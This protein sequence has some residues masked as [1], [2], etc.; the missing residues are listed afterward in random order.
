MKRAE[1]YKLIVARDCM[2][3]VAEA[4]R[5]ALKLDIDA[6]HE[7]FN[8]IHDF[9]VTSYGRA[10]SEMKPFGAISGKYGKIQDSELRRIHDMLIL[11]RNKHVAHT[12]YI[13]S[14]IVFYP[15]NTKRPDGSKD[16]KLQFE[17]LKNY[18]SH[19]VY[20]SILKLAGYQAGIMQA[21]IEKAIISIYGEN[22][23]GIKEITELITVEDINALAK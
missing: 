3:S 16:S 1:L 10:F 23:V 9:I 15:P 8:T 7:L 4:T 14:K 22:G 17:V 5:L 20:N 21:N 2:N 11:R 12:D 18:F 6:N 13:A 19:N